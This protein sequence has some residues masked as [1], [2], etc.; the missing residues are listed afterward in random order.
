MNLPFDI[1]GTY[2]E[3]NDLVFTYRDELG[4]PITPELGEEK[5]KKIKDL[6]QSIINFRENL[7]RNTGLTQEELSYLNTLTAMVKKGVNLTSDQ[8]KAMVR[9]LEKQSKTGLNVTEAAEFQSILSELG[10]IS[11]KIP[12][13]Y[14]MDALNFNLSRLNKPEVTSDKVDEYINSEEFQ[15]L[16]DEDELLS[17]WFEDNHISKKYRDKNKV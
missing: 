6:E 12:T 13:D 1:A 17:Q 4:Q 7:A 8:K 2:Q 10:D 3:I 9:L 15:D 11:E 16:L 14:Y 5:I